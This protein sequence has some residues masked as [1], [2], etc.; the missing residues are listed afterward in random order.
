MFDER[1]IGL[2][3]ETHASCN[4][5]SWF[6]SM[7]LINLNK[8]KVL[9]SFAEKVANDIKVDRLVPYMMNDGFIV[10]TGR[11]VKECN[12]E[13]PV[14]FAKILLLCFHPSVCDGYLGIHKTQSEWSGIKQ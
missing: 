6:S 10:H 1:D 2:V 13:V 4:V 9:T 11:S 14:S 7:V 12:I 3:Q 8:T 5:P